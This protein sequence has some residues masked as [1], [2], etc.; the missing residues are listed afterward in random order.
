MR[1]PLRSCLLAAL[2]VAT[3]PVLR[4]AETPA[5]RVSVAA[6]ANLVYVLDALRME[7]GRTAPDATLTITTGASGSLFAQIRNG[8]PFDV[9]LSADTDYP[10][11]AV[12]VG[13]ADRDSLRVFATGRL[14]AWTTRRDLDLTDLAAA[15]CSARVQKIALPQPRTAP[16]GRA[17]QAAL[18]ALGAWAA[19]EPKVVLGENVSQ[20]A[21]FVETG[22]ADLGLVALSLVRS[23]RLQAAGH[24]QE[25]PARLHPG[26]SLDHAGVLTRRGTSNAA[27]RRFLEFLGQPAARTILRDHGY[28]VPD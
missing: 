9:F 8:A 3:L 12:A 16:Y 17:A 23:P 14:V 2:A 24:W 4:A 28:G 27:A 22:S 25:I 5:A 21:Q 19:A 6:A 13:A 18:E 7:F 15:V 1:P 11:Q 10:Q 26:V 20:A